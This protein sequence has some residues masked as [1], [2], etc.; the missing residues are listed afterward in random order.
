VQGTTIEEQAE[1]AIMNL[2]AVLEK[3]GASLESVVK[4]TVF[5]KSMNDYAKMNAVYERYLTSRP[6]RL[7]VEAARLPRDALIEIEAVAELEE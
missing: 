2:K 3:A 1:R 6:A 4:A 5:L 7:C